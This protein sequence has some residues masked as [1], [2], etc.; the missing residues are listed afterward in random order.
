MEVEDYVKLWKECGIDSL[1]TYQKNAGT[2]KERVEEFKSG[3]INYKNFWKA[4]E[5]VTGVDGVANCTKSN[6]LNYIDDNHSKEQANSTNRKIAEYSGM[7]GWL[8]LLIDNIKIRNERV[9]VLE[10]G[11][12]YGAFKEELDQLFPD[13]DYDYVGFDVYPKFDGVVEVMGTDGCLTDDQVEEYKNSFNIAYCFNVFQHLEFD[14]VK[15][16]ID[17][18]DQMLYDDKYAAFLGMFCVAGEG[19]VDESFHYG[20][21]IKLPM[22]WEVDS[23]FQGKTRVAKTEIYNRPFMM[24]NLYMEMTKEYVK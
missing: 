2:L 17:Q 20:Q 21:K 24:Y 12:G 19:G 7:N 14:Q 5:L 10:I 18:I 4:Q 9:R 1:D 6:R 15:R 3:R 22:K 13:G 8:K 11:P 16:Y 23:F